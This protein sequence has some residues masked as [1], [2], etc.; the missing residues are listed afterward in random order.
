MKPISGKRMCKIL[1]ARG[2]T[3]DRIS[4]SHHVFVFGDPA[5]SLPVPVHGNRDLTPGTQ[6]SIMRQAKLTDA[7]L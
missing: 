5:V 1:K 7:D 3:F 6:K 4:G 2:W